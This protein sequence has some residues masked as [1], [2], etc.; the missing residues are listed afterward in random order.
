[1]SPTNTA[2]T[3]E[4]VV[5]GVLR[6]SMVKAIDTGDEHEGLKP[7]RG[8]ESLQA[9]EAQQALRRREY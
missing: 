5:Q 6:P 1:M 2:R 7:D 8:A 4:Q 9:S 3:R